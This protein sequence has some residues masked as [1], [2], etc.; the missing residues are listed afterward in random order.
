MSVPDT[1]CV[2]VAS[3]SQYFVRMCLFLNATQTS[4]HPECLI[5]MGGEITEGGIQIELCPLIVLFICTC[6]LHCFSAQF[7][8]RNYA[9]Q[10]MMQAHPKCLG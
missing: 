3:L 2:N 5:P 7:T 4:S 10:L 6:C 1:D 8:I 9:N